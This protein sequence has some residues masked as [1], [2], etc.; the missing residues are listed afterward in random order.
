MLAPSEQ[1]LPSEAGQ[2][3]KPKWW[4]VQDSNL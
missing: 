1:M 3:R 2:H 4:A